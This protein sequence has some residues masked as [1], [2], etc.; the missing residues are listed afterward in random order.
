MYN[1]LYMGRIFYHLKNGLSN[2]LNFDTRASRAEYW[3]ILFFSYL[4]LFIFAVSVGYL[5]LPLGL[6]DLAQFVVV[7]LIIS[8]GI[9]RM[10]DVGRSGWWILFPFINFV[11]TISNSEPK[12]NRWGNIP[13]GV[14][15]FTESEIVDNKS[16]TENAAYEERVTFQEEETIE[17]ELYEDASKENEDIEALEIEIEELKKR[18]EEALMKKKEQASKEAAE[19]QKLTNEIEKLKSEIQDLEEN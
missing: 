2:V 15:V 6:I 16:Q 5:G 18:K 7:V 8:A 10:H 17:N 1:F 19:I 13:D 11:Y 12:Q 4:W 9:R 14:K 3:T